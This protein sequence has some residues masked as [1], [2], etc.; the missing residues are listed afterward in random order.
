MRP[1][2]VVLCLVL[3]MLGLGGEAGYRPSPV[4]A[5][6]GPSDAPPAQYTVPSSAAR[7]FLGQ[8]AMQSV[9]SGA[10]LSRGQ[11]AID[12]N[13]LHYLSGIAS[14]NG[15]DAGGHR[16]TWVG[17]L[18]QFHQTARDGMVIDIL[19]P[20]T[21]RLFGKMYLHPV[22]GGDLVGQIALPTRQYAIHWHKNLSL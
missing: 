13:S 22:K 11:M 17:T 21:S 5:T 12:F 18:Y 3:L 20:A 4:S 14:F 6:T 7:R 1:A 10:R 2:R 8:Y 9:A 19:A 15:Y 16:T